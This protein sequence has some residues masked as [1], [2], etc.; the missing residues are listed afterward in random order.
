MDSLN[1]DDHWKT[2]AFKKFKHL[3]KYYP[4]FDKTFKKHTSKFDV[5]Q[6]LILLFIVFQT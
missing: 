1:V 4:K 2:L 3:C 6:F 5:R